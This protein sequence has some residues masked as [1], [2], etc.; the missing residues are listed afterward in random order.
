MELNFELKWVQ[1][2]TW[3]TGLVYLC[4]SINGATGFSHMGSI[5]HWPVRRSSR[6]VGFV[7]FLHHGL[8]ENTE[9]GL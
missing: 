7:R 4:K 5:G 8:T 9:L 6:S 3:A 1:W 2:D